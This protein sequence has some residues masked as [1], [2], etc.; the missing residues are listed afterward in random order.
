MAYRYKKT[1]KKISFGANPGVRYVAAMAVDGRVKT[2]QLF[3]FVERDTS[4]DH[5]D[6]EMMFGALSDAIEEN[7]EM[8]RG[9]NI[10]TLGTFSPNLRVTGEADKDN[11]S[12]NNVKK[13]VVNFRPAKEFQ[14]QM[15]ETPAEKT[16]K[17]N[18]KHE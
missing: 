11:V 12:I 15:K 6:I 8:G 13:I 18:L 7:V 16:T 4:I 9:V 10:K 5:A 1:R 17:F 2:D 3:E 14:Q